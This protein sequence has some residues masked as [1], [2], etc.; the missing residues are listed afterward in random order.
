MT[1]TVSLARFVALVSYCLR[2]FLRFQERIQR[3]SDAA[4]EEFS[5]L[6]FSYFLVQCYNFLRHGSQTPFRMVCCDFI[7]TDACE[8][9]LFLFTQFMESYRINSRTISG[10]YMGEQPE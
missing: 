7:L 1:A 9:C 2:Q 8:P 3:L 5:N 10:G 6:A 4:T